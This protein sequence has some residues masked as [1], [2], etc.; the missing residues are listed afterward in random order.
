[1]AAEQGIRI[2]TIGL[3]SGE[4][5]PLEFVDPNTGQRFRGTYR[6]GVD[7]ELLT[8]LAAR[9]GGQYFQASSPG[10]LEGVFQGIDTLERVESRLRVQVNREPMHRFFLMVGFIFVLLDQVLRRLLLQEVL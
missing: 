7:P 8:Q 5:V 1:L 2:Y 6:G 10:A 4:E 3:G 9:T